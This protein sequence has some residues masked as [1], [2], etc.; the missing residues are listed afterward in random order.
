MNFAGKA[1]VVVVFL[2][3]ALWMAFSVA[4]YTTHKNYKDMVL[5]DQERDGEPVGLQ[6]K[7]QKARQ[8]NQELKDEYDNLK[9]QLD[10]E[11]EA[12]LSALAKLEAEYQALIE[13][14]AKT[15]ERLDQLEQQRRD[16]VDEMTDTQTELGKLRVRIKDLDDQIDQAEHEWQVAFGSS[17]RLTEELHHEV[18]VYQ[19]L[20]SRS[21]ILK[22]DLAE[23]QRV[24][25]AS[26]ATGAPSGPPTRPAASGN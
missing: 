24:A 25:Q 19:A 6:A 23:A 1:F 7:L 2:M 8:V 4:I 14:H 11:I 12:K 13:A 26:H 5:T 18:N 9:L 10:R 3:S 20:A 22:E 15:R 21:R 16:K 17:I